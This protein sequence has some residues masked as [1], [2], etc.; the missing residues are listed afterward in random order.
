MRNLYLEDKKYILNTYNRLDLIIERGEGSYLYDSNGEKYLDMYSGI[1][2]NNLGHDKEI[3]S[4]IAMQ[5]SKYIHLS[6]YF[7]SESTI[8]LAKLLVENTF[9]SKVFFTNSGAEA[10]E[11]AIKLCRKYG[12]KL[13]EEKYQI[14]SAYNSF[15]GRTCGG[16]T[17][18][19][20]DKY[21]NDFKP[22][23]SG[24][25]YFRYNDIESLNEKVSD[26][27][28]AVF[29]EIIQGEGGIVEISQEFIDNL[30]ELSKRHNFLIVI[31][32]IQT[33]IGR[34]GDVFA[35]EKYGFTPHVVTLAKSLG[36]GIPLGAMLVCKDLEGIFEPGDHGT[37]FG[38]NP[39][40]CA[41]GEY[42]VNE[43]INTNLCNDVKEKGN[44]LLSKL[45][46]I[47]EKY[48]N[49]IR[50]LRGRGLMIGI[51][52]GEYAG[53]IKETALNKKLLLNVTNKTIIRLLPPLNIKMHELDEFIRL[54]EEILAEI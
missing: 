10:N 38:G 3:A 51:E 35:Y 46:K 19:G 15:H 16:L 43:V 26:N 37:T 29:L 13:S 28:C 4:R 27:T 49:I 6:N 25:D 48:P 52:A 7:V 33:G 53:I 30:N 34:T 50:E 39:V 2:V 42:V 41:A 23:I 21:Q 1:S 11:A 54:F 40:A 8:N 47:K 22:L 44:Y 14:L 31:D 36:G 45:Q 17:L 20:Q 32:E 18:T 24:V 5:A 12:K 9:A